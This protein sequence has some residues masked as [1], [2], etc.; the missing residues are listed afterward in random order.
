MG[1]FLFFV[2]FQRLGSSLL[3]VHVASWR[4]QRGSRSLEQTLAAAASDG[5]QFTSTN[6]KENT[7]HKHG[8][9]EIEEDYDVPEEIEMV[10]EVLL[11]ALT[12]RDSTVVRWSAAKG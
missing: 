8:K 10:V 5:D 2:F 7:K 12:D 9:V 11:E 1:S 3:P 4:Y 6:S